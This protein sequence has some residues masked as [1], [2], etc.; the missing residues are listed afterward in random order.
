MESGDIVEVHVEQLGGGS[1]AASDD[2]S[3]DEDW[4]D[5]VEVEESEEPKEDLLQKTVD[6]KVRLRAVF[7]RL[8]KELLAL[9]ANN[10][11]LAKENNNLK[12]AKNE[13]IVS[14]KS[15]WWKYRTDITGRQL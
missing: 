8:K 13:L 15:I 5:W 11:S 3:D 10:R 7:D 1:N 12:I 14:L 9:K 6:E 4:E 2:S